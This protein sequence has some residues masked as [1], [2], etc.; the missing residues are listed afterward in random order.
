M[1]TSSNR[2]P[3]CAHARPAQ[4]NAARR[5]ATD[6]QRT[7]IVRAAE[8]ILCEGGAEAV[9]VAGVCSAA[10]VPRSA[11]HAIFKDSAQCLLAVFDEASS[12]ACSAMT[13]PYRAADSW[14][15]AIRGALSQLL[16]FLDRRPRLACFLIVD[17]LAGDT[18]MRTRREDVLVHLAYRLE[19]D[20]PPSDAGSLPAPYGA[21]AV[22]GAVASILHGRLIE[23]PTPSLQGLHRS[24]MG[25]IVLPY[26]DVEGARRELSRPAPD[27]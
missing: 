20:R 25:L 13:D 4:P 6:E 23:E 15:E 19:A 1:D 16:A 10:G 8:R 24:L 7:L 18:R 17:S 12:Q 21:R 22:V 5:G 27:G 11:F 9:T 14:V 26:L 3:A 2:G